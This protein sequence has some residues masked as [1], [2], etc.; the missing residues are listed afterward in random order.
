M[1]ALRAAGLVLVLLFTEARGNS[2]HQLSGVKPELLITGPQNSNSRRR[3]APSCSGVELSMARPTRSQAWR[4]SSDSRAACRASA[5]R[6][7]IASAV[8][9]DTKAPYLSCCVRV[10]HPSSP[11]V[12]APGKDGERVRPEVASTRIPP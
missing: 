12:G 11:N 7:T 2:P 4:T 3:L 10:G 1:A 9:A 6:R 5:V 8:A